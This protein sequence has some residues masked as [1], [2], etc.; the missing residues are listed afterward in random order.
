MIL[1]ILGLLP[2]LPKIILGAET[3]FGHGSGASKKQSVLSDITILLNAFSQ[4]LGTP[5][6]DSSIIEFISTYIEDVVTLF[7]KAGIM[8][9]GSAIPKKVEP[10]RLP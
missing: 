2:I 4:T 3:I 5:G 10:V 8:T 7:N 6:A 9:H 1:A